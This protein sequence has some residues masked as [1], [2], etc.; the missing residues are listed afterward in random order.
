MREIDRPGVIAL[1]RLDGL[2]TAQTDARIDLDMGAHPRGAGD[3]RALQHAGAARIDV[4][5]G[6]IALHGGDRLD[7]LTDAAMVMAAAAEQAGLVEVDV[8][9]DEA[10]KHQPAIAEDFA[11][12]RFQ[13]RRDRGD[14]AG[15]DADIDRLGR[16]R[17]HRAA[18]DQV[19]G[20]FRGH[21][22]K[23]ADARDKGSSRLC[24]G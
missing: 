13:P 12:F 22:G 19:K 5:D 15:G 18:E 6:K 3:N 10:G 24:A 8:G 23:L 14:P 16:F 7:G 9:V 20:C 17:R 21:R 4:L 1:Q 2:E 11:G